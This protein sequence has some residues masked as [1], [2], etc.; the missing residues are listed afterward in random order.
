MVGDDM[1]CMEIRGVRLCVT[2]SFFFVI[3]LLAQGSGFEELALL[4]GLLACICHELGH[5]FAM[6]I[7]GSAPSSVTL[8]GGGIKL[9]PDR[10]RFHGRAAETV[11]LLSGC[12]VNLA[13]SVVFLAMGLPREFYITGLV[14][15]VFNLLP[16]S[17]FDGGRILS[18]W[19]SDKA[20]GIITAAATALTGA[21]AILLLIRGQLSPS[22]GAT[23]ALILLSELGQH[24]T[25]TG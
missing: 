21:F 25:T 6:S 22:L 8:Y 4:S 5:I 17:Y 23:F 14:L 3:A 7:F 11:I 13:M 19:L 9:V 15:C 1:L 12:A 24:R 16:F 10:E 18:L 2:F 20:C